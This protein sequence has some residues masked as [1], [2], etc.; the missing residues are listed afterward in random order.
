MRWRR[1]CG[2]SRRRLTPGVSKSRRRE[3]H[4]L[5]GHFV[6][7]LELEHLAGIIGGGDLQS[8]TF[9]DLAHVS[10]LLR[11]ALGE[12]TGPEHAPMVVVAEQAISGAPH[13]HHVL[14]MRANSA[15]DA[16]H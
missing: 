4:R 2:L 5:E 11:I 15:E 13:H 16:E 3:L 10:D 6:S 7:A 12:T 14:R 1:C 9:D 8:E